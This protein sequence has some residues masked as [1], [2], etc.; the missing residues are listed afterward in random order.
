[1]RLKSPQPPVRAPNSVQARVDAAAFAL[2]CE[3]LNPTVVLVRARM[4]GGSPN[5]IAPALQR[6]RRE[7]GQ[8]L[9]DNAASASQTV[10]RDVVELAQAL[11]WRAVIEAR[12]AP[13][14]SLSAADALRQFSLAVAA[15]SRQATRL[16]TADARRSRVDRVETPRT[17]RL[18]PVSDSATTRKRTVA[19]RSV[20]GSATTNV[21]SKARGKPAHRKTVRR[22]TRAP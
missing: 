5:R 7:F 4:G 19:K 11:W 21:A 13:M 6:W 22:P 1:M 10:P 17:R 3:G 9:A 16:R 12:R 2:L 15:L 14:D 8:Q 18:R 20:S